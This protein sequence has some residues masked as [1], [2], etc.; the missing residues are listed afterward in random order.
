M[1]NNPQ[2]NTTVISF[3]KFRDLP[4][5]L[6]L[7]YNSI[8]R[9]GITTTTPNTRIEYDWKL[10][11]QGNLKD[12]DTRIVI[13]GVEKNIFNY[14]KQ[15]NQTAIK[16]KNIQTGQITTITQSGFVPVTVLTNSSNLLNVS[17]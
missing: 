10:D 15:I 14:K 7:V 16:N 13:K 9:N 8:T 1:T 5:K 11:N 4:T 17:Y 2:N 3:K 12:L 6:I